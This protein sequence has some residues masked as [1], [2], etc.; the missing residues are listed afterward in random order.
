M[1]FPCAGRFDSLLIQA[2]GL[3]AF[4]SKGRRGMGPLIPYIPRKTFD[5]R[6]PSRWPPAYFMSLLVH[7]FVQGN[8]NRN[9]LTQGFP[10]VM[11]EMAHPCSREGGVSC[12]SKA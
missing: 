8:F 2:L 4:S 5:P 6:A 3:K 1:S 10:W 12:A 11:G 9:S 7:L